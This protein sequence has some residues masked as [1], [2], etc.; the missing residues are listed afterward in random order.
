MSCVSLSSSCCSSAPRGVFSRR[1]PHR[2]VSCRHVFVP[3]CG[4]FQRP[5][6]V[7]NAVGFYESSVAGGGG[8]RVVRSY[9]FDCVDPER[10]YILE[11]D[12]LLDRFKLFG[13]ANAGGV[14][15]L[16]T[17]FGFFKKPALMR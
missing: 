16:R 5:K 8:V 2:Y 10:G 3:P 17:R 1:D 14:P 11:S 6:I 13:R 12:V 9:N 4:V 15:C 7:H